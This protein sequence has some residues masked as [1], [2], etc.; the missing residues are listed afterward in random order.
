MSTYPFFLVYPCGYS[1]DGALV[2]HLMARNPRMLLID[3]RLSPRS[4]LPEWNRSALHTR[5]GKRYRWAGAFLGN[6]NYATS[7]PITLAGPETGIAGLLRYTQ[8]GHSL[9]LLCG[10]HDY[11]RCHMQVIVSLLQ[12]ACPTVLAVLPEDVRYV[13]TLTTSHRSQPEEEKHRR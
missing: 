12:Q 6:R 2:H 9:I 7:G 5:Y 13:A 11:T 1:R 8:E 4:R 3:T 10:C